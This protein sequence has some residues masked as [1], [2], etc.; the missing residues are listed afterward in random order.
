MNER[1]A[2]SYKLQAA[3]S[4]MQCFFTGVQLVFYFG[5][6]SANEQFDLLSFFSFSQ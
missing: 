1:K 5:Q 4:L 6:R 2:V 3:S